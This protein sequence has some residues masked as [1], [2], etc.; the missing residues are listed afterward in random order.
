MKKKINKY[1]GSNSSTNDNN[2]INNS[3]QNDINAVVLNTF[4]HI[5]INYNVSFMDMKHLDCIHFGQ[6][7]RVDQKGNTDK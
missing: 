3:I 6:P 1:G 5:E 4:M 7:H 2:N